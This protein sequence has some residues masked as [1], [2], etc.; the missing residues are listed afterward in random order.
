MQDELVERDFTAQGPNELCLAD[1]IEHWTAALVPVDLSG[2]LFLCAAGRTGHIEGNS[3]SANPHAGVRV[4]RQIS[5][6]VASDASNN[7]SRC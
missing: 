5:L 4:A 3:S 6:D 7:S 1:I 2:A